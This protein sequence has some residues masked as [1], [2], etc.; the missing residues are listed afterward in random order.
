[1][2]RKITTV[3]KKAKAKRLI[4]MTQK[5]TLLIKRGNKLQGLKTKIITLQNQ[6]IKQLPV[7]LKKQVKQI[8]QIKRKIKKK[9]VKSHCLLKQPLILR[10]LMY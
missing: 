5:L 9:K 2:T 6:T 3:G 7:L 8:H 4:A 1:M 10:N